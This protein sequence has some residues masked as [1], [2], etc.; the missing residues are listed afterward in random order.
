MSNNLTCK[1]SISASSL[2]EVRKIYMSKMTQRGCSQTL[3]DKCRDIW[4]DVINDAIDAEAECSMR[5]IAIVHEKKQEPAYI[6]SKENGKKDSSEGDTE[7]ETESEESNSETEVEID[8]SL[9]GSECECAS[10]INLNNM[11][12]PS[13]EFSPEDLDDLANDL[14]DIQE[15]LAPSI[16]YFISF[17]TGALLDHLD[18]V[19]D[20]LDLQLINL[21]EMLDRLKRGLDQVKAIRKA[22]K[23]EENETSEDEEVKESEQ[24]PHQHHA[25]KSPVAKSPKHRFSPAAKVKVQESD[26]D[27]DSEREIE[28]EKEDFE[29]LFQ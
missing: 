14:K 28:A 4:H 11:P 21:T 9:D 24:H 26:G 12:S 2:G 15:G 1:P 20:A 25:T 17:Q 22:V 3:K 7:S 16:H 18:E 19:R 29:T 8:P 27:A 6:Q 5:G 23:A 13:R 10:G